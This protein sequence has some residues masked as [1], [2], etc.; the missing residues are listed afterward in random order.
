MDYQ[1]DLLYGTKFN[2]LVR[3]S[4]AHKVVEHFY[5]G[6][7][8]LVFNHITNAVQLYSTPFCKHL[9]QLIRGNVKPRVIYNNNNNKYKLNQFTETNVFVLF[10]EKTV[11]LQKRTPMDQNTMKITATQ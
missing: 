9:I 11:V 8:F 4:A 5:H 1:C 3:R 2:S 10:P 7:R 6:N